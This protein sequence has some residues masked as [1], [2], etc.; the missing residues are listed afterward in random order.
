M[1][2]MMMPGKNTTALQRYIQIVQSVTGSP[3]YAPAPCKW[4]F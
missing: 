3:Q 4:S 2:M 1:M